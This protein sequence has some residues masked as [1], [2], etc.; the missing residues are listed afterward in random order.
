MASRA[1]LRLLSGACDFQ[2]FAEAGADDAILGNKN[3]SYFMNGR[4]M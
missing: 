1:Q 3:G 2:G 4:P